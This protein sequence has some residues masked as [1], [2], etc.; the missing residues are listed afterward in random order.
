MGEENAFNDIFFVN[1]NGKFV[2][3]HGRK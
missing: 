2:F 3:V 1:A